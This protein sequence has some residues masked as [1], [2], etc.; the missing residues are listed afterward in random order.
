MIKKNKKELLRYINDLRELIGIKDKS[1]YSKK[2]D[3]KSKSWSKESRDYF[4]NCLSKDL[5]SN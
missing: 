1:S 4:F 5:Q 3:E 2:L